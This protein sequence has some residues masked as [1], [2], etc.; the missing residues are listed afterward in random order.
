MLVIWKN[1]NL[2]LSVIEGKINFDQVLWH[3]IRNIDVV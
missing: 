1:R 2:Y 3:Q